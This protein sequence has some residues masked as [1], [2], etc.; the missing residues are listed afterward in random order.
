MFIMII[1][2]IMR[3]MIDCSLDAKCGRIRAKCMRMREK[4]LWHEDKTQ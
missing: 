1:I 2:I 4:V 3:G